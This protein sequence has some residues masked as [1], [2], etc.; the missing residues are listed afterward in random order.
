MSHSILQ[1]RESEN[2]SHSFVNMSRNKEF[3]ENYR[4]NYRKI[5][6][7]CIVENE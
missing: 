5:S 7:N 3:I 4:K 2:R 6:F 1:E